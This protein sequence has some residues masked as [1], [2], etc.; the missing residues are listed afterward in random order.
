MAERRLYR[1]ILFDLFRTV[2]V[3]DDL[4]PTGRVHE[5]T[6]RSAMGAL[7]APAYELLPQVDFD[8]LLDAIVAVADEISR[9]YPPEYNEIPSAERYR[10]A[11]TRVGVSGPL[12]PEI[13]ERLS[14][15]QMT[16]FLAHATVPENHVA[17]LRELRQ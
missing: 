14:H 4:A 7:R 13:A 3:F 2:V 11:L 8:A 6:W 9:T 15:L 10:R 1:V 12:L 16:Q 17:L 5:P